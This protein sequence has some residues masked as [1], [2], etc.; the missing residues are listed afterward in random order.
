[1]SLRDKVPKDRLVS[2]TVRRERLLEEMKKHIGQKNA[3]TKATLFMTV[4]GRKALKYSELE[5]FY[6]WLQLKK[7][8]NYIRRKTFCFI[9][10]IPKD[11]HFLF[12]VAK[13]QKDIQFYTTLMEGTAKKCLYMRDRCKLAVKNQFWR[14]I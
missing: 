4:Y 12:C 3:T 1:M 9:V 13:D 2:A 11:D 10:V 8:M 7:D 14:K 5:R 6:L